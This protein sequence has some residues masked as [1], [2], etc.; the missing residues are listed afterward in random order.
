MWT[1]RYEEVTDLSPDCLWPVLADVARWPEIDAGIDWL[2]IDTPP[3]PGVAFVLKPK[4][5]PRLSFT[6]GDFA[7]PE[8]YSDIC[9]MPLAQMTTRHSLVPHQG[10][11]LIRVEIIITGPLAGLWGLIVGRKHAAGLSAQTAR[12]IA[13]AREGEAERVKSVRRA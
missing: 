6:I 3:A 4:G 11:T 2:R 1:H 5:G 10:G 7:P 13:G 12:F 9:R 8:R